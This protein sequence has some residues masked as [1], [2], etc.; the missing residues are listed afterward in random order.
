MADNE[1]PPRAHDLDTWRQVPVWDLPTRLFH[2]CIVVLVAT[3]WATIE[4]DHLVWHR[5]SG[6][7]ILAALNFRVLWGLFGSETARFAQFARSPVIGLRH[8]GRLVRMR[9]PDIQVGHNPAGGWMVLILLGVLM[10][11]VGTGLFANSFDGEDVNGPFAHLV[12]KRLSNRLTGLHAQWFNVIL[13]VVT[14][15]VLAIVGY[16]V[17]KRHNLTAA[18]LTGRKRLPPTLRPPR[19]AGPVRALVTLAVAVGLTVAIA[20]V[21]GG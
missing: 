3:S 5:L 2:W 9:G 20:S 18:M 19:F 16:A 6:Y 7:A 17:F 10:I 13:A 21:G 12:A 11:Q 14:V 4:T 1:T 8:L 15:H